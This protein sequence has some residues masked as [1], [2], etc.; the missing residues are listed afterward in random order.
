L[1][2]IRINCLLANHSAL[3]SIIQTPLYY[4]EFSGSQRY[5]ISY[6]QLYLYNTDTSLLRTVLLVLKVPIFIQ[7]RPLL[8]RYLST[9]NSSLSPRDT[10]LRT[11]GSASIMQTPL[12][13]RQ[14]S[15]SWRY[16]SSYNLD[17]YNTDI[18]LLRTV[19][20]VPEIPIFIQSLPIP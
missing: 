4:G 6:D 18:S 17:L 7:S 2:P 10:K 12:Y 15:L 19:S 13:Y 20:L 1:V 11:I 16:P 8:P 9:T 3:F 5:Q 14:F